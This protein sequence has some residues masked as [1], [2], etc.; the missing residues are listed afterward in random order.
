M[1]ILKRDPIEIIEREVAGLQARR[2]ALQGRLTQAQADLATA[3]ERRRK[4][5]L[6]GGEVEPAT[7][8]H[9][10]DIKDSLLD[11]LATIDRQIADAESKLAA[12]RDRA[13][14]KVE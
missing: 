10:I 14:R 8:A 5:L 2:E 12:E 3:V 13:A 11:A 7:I 6:E 9:L 1:G 4:T